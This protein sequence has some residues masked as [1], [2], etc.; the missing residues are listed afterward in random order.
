MDLRAAARFAGKLVKGRLEEDPAE[1]DA[2]HSPPIKFIGNS[3][4]IDPR[5]AKNFERSGRAAAFRNVR[6]F[7]QAHAGING[8]GIERWHIGLRHYP[9]QTTVIK[10]NSAI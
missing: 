5:R 3:L 7:E 1:M 6:P 8:G 10:Q 4:R 9:R 2:R